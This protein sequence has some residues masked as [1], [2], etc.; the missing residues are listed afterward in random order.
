M[1]I[2]VRRQSALF[3]PDPKRVIARFYIP[4][5]PA[6]AQ[7]IIRSILAMPEER[8]SQ[9][10]AQVLRSFSGRHRNIYQVFLSHF[11]RV[12]HWVREMGFNSQEISEQKK[13]FI[14]SYFTMEYSVE[15]AAFFNPSIVEDPFQ[16]NI[17]KDHKKVILSFRATGEGHISSIEFRQGVLDK[18][19]VLHVEPPG[20]L[21]ETAE[22]VK[23]D[24]Y[25][26]KEF[27]EKLGG[28]D[29]QKDVL[30]EIMDR[31]GDDFIYGELRAG[32]E[33]R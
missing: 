5:G 30:S 9:H 13:M 27:E 29:I 17:E 1:S 15:S 28:I 6:E 33:R 22:I 32:I 14:G 10:S 26:K 18:E 4:G 25:D 23:R 19:N 8:A 3:Q 24:V 11:G 31:L 2:A 7:R 16:E 20:K 12:D 21:A